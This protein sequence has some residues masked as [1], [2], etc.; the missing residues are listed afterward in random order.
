MTF[1]TA[2]KKKVTYF[3][4]IFDYGDLRREEPLKHLHTL[5]Q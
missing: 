4:A 1:T 3:I 2:K 5:W